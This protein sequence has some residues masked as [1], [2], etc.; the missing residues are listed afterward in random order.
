[1]C[2][3]WE[4]ALRGLRVG[5]ASVVISVVLAGSLQHLKRESADFLHI[6]V[7][8]QVNKLRVIH[9]F[10]IEQCS[11]ILHVFTISPAAVRSPSIS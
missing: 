11:S 10:G 8:F 7:R 6:D 3:V 4:A 2:R 5:F 9:S 1:M